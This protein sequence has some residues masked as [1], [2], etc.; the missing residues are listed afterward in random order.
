MSKLIHS[1][2]PFLKRHFLRILHG[3]TAGK[4][5]LY[6]VQ[7]EHANANH[8]ENITL[9]IIDIHGQ[10]LCMRHHNDAKQY[11]KRLEAV[12]GEMQRN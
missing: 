2:H 3:L 11:F 9:A 7:P 4:L 1:C 5:S 8:L 10:Q 6:K 12:W